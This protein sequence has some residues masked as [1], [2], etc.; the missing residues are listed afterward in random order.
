[1]KLGVGIAVLLAL[2]GTVGLA[3]GDVA[4]SPAVNAC[5]FADTGRAGRPAR[6]TRASPSSCRTSSCVSLIRRCR[7]ESTKSTAS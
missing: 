5:R 7:R 2:V 6:P 1:M 3:A 4:A